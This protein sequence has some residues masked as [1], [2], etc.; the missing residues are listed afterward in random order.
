[1]KLITRDTDYAIRALCYLAKSKNKVVS[2]RQLVKALKIPNPFLRKILQ[3]LNKKGVLESYKGLGGGFSL[4]IPA[5][6]ILIM[7]LLEIF[8]GPFKL[9]ECFLKKIVCPNTRTCALRRKINKIE[10]Y[11]VRELRSISVGSLL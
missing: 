8:Q 5:D 4:N 3:V 7:D 11:V 6:K 9:N 10:K 1:M 2:V